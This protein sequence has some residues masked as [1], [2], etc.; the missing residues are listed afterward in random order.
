[1]QYLINKNKKLCFY[2]N[3]RNLKLSTRIRIMYTLSREDFQI[4][5]SEFDSVSHCKLAYN[6]LLNQ[7]RVYVLGGVS[8][9]PPFDIFFF[10]IF[11][12]I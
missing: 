5:F 4:V 3:T 7:K 6:I 11:I 8:D 9:D 2:R 1:M 10:K 12:I